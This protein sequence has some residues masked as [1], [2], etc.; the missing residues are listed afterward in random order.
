M[1]EELRAG[2]FDEVEACRG[3]ERNP[4]R[5]GKADGGW[6]S[7]AEFAV[8]WA[9][10]DS[11]ELPQR[12]FLYPRLDNV[13]ERGVPA[14][15]RMSEDNA[16]LYR[17]LAQLAALETE[18]RKTP[19]VYLGAQ[20]AENRFEPD[21]AKWACHGKQRVLAF[22]EFPGVSVEGKAYRVS[23]EI[24]HLTQ[25][26]RSVPHSPLSHWAFSRATFTIDFLRAVAAN[27]RTG[28]E[29]KG[30]SLRIR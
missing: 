1:A 2:P 14:P 26:Q 4:W 8:L 19:C 28:L 15:L 9:W 12:S 6:L 29:Y 5:W 11:N 24:L 27:V 18:V 13:F 17:A 23:L 25:H 10:N 30:D 7:Q 16:G 3:F 22:F 20:I 21:P